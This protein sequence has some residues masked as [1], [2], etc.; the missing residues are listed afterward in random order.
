[1]IVFSFLFAYVGENEKRNIDNAPVANLPAEIGRLS[2][3]LSLRIANT[4]ISSL[5][6]EFLELTQ[7]EFLRL[8]RNELKSVPDLSEFTNLK[9]LYVAV[10]KFL[11]LKI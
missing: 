11:R 2:R 9:I 8:P 6:S 4:K 7:L 1:M 5:P 3:L 10:L